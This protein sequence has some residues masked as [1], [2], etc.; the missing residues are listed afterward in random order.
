MSSSIPDLLKIGAIPSNLQMDVETTIVEPVV[1]T[2]SFVRFGL[3]R[4]GFLHSNSKVLLSLDASSFTDIR[5]APAAGTQGIAAPSGKTFYPVNIGVSSLVQRV[6][7]LSGNTVIQE[8]DDFNFLESYKSLFVSNENNKEKEQY[9]SARLMNYEFDYNNAPQLLANSIL[10]DVEA[11]GVAIDNGM[12]P[13]KAR[14]ATGNVTVNWQSDTDK[15]VKDIGDI[16][17]DPVYQLNLSQLVPFLKQTQLPL[18]MF[19][20][21]VFLEITLQPGT[22]RVVGNAHQTGGTAAEKTISYTMNA[23]E[24]RI[25]CDYISYPEDIMQ[26]WAAANKNLS[27]TY[28]DYELSKFTVGNPVGDTAV[29]FIRNTGGAGK[30]VTKMICGLGTE[31]GLDG[32]AELS[33]THLQGP[34]VASHPPQVANT[35]NERVD[36]NLRYNDRYLYP[37]TVKNDSY[38]FNNVLTAEG[39]PPFVTKNLYAGAPVTQTTTSLG[40]FEGRETTTLD[41]QFF[42]QSFKLNRNERI[43]QKGI[44]LYQKYVGLAGDIT[45]QTY[46]LRIWLEVIKTATL[47]DGK[48]RSTFA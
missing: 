29:D 43:N 10:P 12:C 31:W 35:S 40:K 7:L 41:N 47:V 39:V 19:D 13:N 20:E 46:T 6:R 34:F 4:S 23:N 16:A 45:N 27:F 37:I 32:A 3:Q 38:H 2:E 14:D 17:R 30:L 1:Q 44:E 9:T 36:T 21:Q 33:N 25:V 5:A 18:F 26:Q 48:L 8:I 15:Y 22:K 42:W 24:T 28:H 11:L